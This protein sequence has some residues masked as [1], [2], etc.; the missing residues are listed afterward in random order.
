MPRTELEGLPDGG[1]ST[2]PAVKEHLGI[3]D[4][5]DDTTITRKVEAVN[6]L[7]R[8]WPCSSLAVGEADWAK[9][10]A[11]V[12]GA[13]MLAARWFRR[14]GSPAG[15]ESVGTL[16]AVYVMRTDPDIAMM[17]GLGPYAGPE[18]G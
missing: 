14:K 17:L 5:R 6:A 7:V 8:A 3:T 15:V 13:N 1:P 16:G 2:L 9:A 11:V 18:V 10:P 12:E 4:A